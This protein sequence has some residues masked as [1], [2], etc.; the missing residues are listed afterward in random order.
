MNKEI[1]LRV[2]H[3]EKPAGRIDGFGLLW[4]YY[5][6]GFKPADHCQKCLLGDRAANFHSRNASSGIA[7]R[8]DRMDA[9]PY[10]YICGVAKGPATDRKVN[11]LHFPLQ[12]QPGS[13]AKV[14]SYNG[15]QFTA[16]N[17]VQIPIP[18]LPEGWRGLPLKHSRCKNFRFGVEYF[19]ADGSVRS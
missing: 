18:E 17:A 14:M 6:R 5:V 10:L 13:S 4:A 2:T 15:Y 12:Y 11:N 9:F 7:V 19:G 3:P 1:V 16:E 8:L